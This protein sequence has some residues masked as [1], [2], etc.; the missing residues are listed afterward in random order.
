MNISIQKILNTKTLIPLNTNLQSN[1]DFE[2]KHIIVYEGSSTP[3]MS[4]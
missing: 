2:I 3:L 1:I 4:Q